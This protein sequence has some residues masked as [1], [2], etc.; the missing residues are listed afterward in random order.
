VSETL[1]KGFARTRK[2]PVNPG[3]QVA[4]QH[5]KMR[6]RTNVLRDEH[7]GAESLA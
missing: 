4:P 1:H 7:L 6:A 2:R 3:S 5:L